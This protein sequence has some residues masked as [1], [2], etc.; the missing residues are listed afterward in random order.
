MAFRSI[1]NCSDADRELW[2]K[3][4]RYPNGTQ[5]VIAG[6]LWMVIICY[7]PS[8]MVLIKNLTHPHNRHNPKK[9]PFHMRSNV[10]L[11]LRTQVAS[12]ATLRFPDGHNMS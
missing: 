1:A 12:T 7:Y 11:E 4:K 3:S 9:R 8:H 2:V 10:H 6:I 5:E